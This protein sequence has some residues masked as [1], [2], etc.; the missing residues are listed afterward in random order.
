MSDK[1][2]YFSYFYLK[3]FVYGKSYLFLDIVVHFREVGEEDQIVFVYCGYFSYDL[4]QIKYL[5]WYSSRSFSIASSI[6]MN[7][8]FENI[9]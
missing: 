9:L 2:S 7:N 1:V 6:V 5:P 4:F 8:Q 3:F